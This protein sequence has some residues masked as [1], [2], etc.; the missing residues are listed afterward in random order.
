VILSCEV[1]SVK[2]SGEI[3]ISAL[4]ELGVAAADA[5]MIDDQPGFCV[6]AEAVGVRA[7][8][9]TR[10]D[11]DGQVSGAGFPV[12]RSLPEVAGLL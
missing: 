3:Y 1:G 12:V 10:G 9:I 4:E 11:L 7:I 6:G 2:P 8:Q 5:V